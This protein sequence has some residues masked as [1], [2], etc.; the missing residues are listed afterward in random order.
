M[1]CQSCTISA[2]Y[3]NDRRGSFFCKK[4]H[5]FCDHTNFPVNFRIFSN[6]S[7]TEPKHCQQNNISICIP[8]VYNFSS[9][10]YYTT[11]MNICKSKTQQP[12]QMMIS[13]IDLSK[14]TSHLTAGIKTGKRKSRYS[15]VEPKL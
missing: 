14:T 8:A 9:I 3:L 5:D 2:I 15:F 11:T 1:C 4:T 7:L 12:K 10:T 13:I 6:K